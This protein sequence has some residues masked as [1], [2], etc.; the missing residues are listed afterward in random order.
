MKMKKK[1]RQLSMRMPEEFVDRLGRCHELVREHTLK[2]FVTK[3]LVDGL[4]RLED[5]LTRDW[6]RK[7]EEK[8]PKRQDPD[9]YWFASRMLRDIA[10]DQHNQDLFDFRELLGLC[11]EFGP[12]RVA[13]WLRA[14][15]FR[16]AVEQD[17]IDDLECLF[18]RKVLQKA[19]REERGRLE[20]LCHRFRSEEDAEELKSVAHDLCEAIKS[21]PD[22]PVA[23]DSNE[24]PPSPEYLEIE[25]RRELA[26]R[27][28]AE[29]D[30]Y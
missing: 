6:G 1:E 4:E 17:M 15:P 20:E 23:S 9:A 28:I 26:R 13:N 12:G 24:Y 10:D 8:V 3:L 16:V 22:C 25:D 18:G 7:Q 29:S 19:T 2:D 21:R 5:D 14:L 11:K 30:E 27:E